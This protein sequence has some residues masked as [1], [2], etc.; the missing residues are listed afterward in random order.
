MSYE[1]HPCFLAYFGYRRKR[2]VHIANQSVFL[3][4]TIGELSKLLSSGLYGCIYKPDWIS[5]FFIE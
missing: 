5:E 2:K 3:T 1:M 4:K